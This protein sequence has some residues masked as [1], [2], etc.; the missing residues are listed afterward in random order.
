MTVPEFRSTIPPH[1]LGKMD[2][3]QRYL[4]ETLSKLEQQSVWVTA[5]VVDHDRDLTEMSTHV[6]KLAQWRSMLTSRWSMA[7][8]VIVMVVPLILKE[9]FDRI[10][11]KKP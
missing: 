11:L 9:L 7:A 2:E 8:A 5:R 1:L 6:N 10:V 3:Q 4:V